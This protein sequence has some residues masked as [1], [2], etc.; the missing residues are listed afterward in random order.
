MTKYLTTKEAAA[1]LEVSP[2]TVVRWVRDGLIP[3]KR[4]GKRIIKIP[5]VEIEKLHNQN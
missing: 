2:S 1:E 4:F 5:R 3:G